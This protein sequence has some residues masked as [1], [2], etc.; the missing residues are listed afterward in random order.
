[1][2]RQLISSAIKGLEESGR[3]HPTAFLDDGSKPNPLNPDASAPLASNKYADRA[4]LTDHF[5]FKVDQ[6]PTNGIGVLDR[7]SR[8]DHENAAA[9]ADGAS[10]SEFLR[11]AEQ[12]DTNFAE[13]FRIDRRKQ[14]RDGASGQILGS[15]TDESRCETRHSSFD[16]ER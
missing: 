10:N 7:F 1:M 2:I 9:T 8:T 11:T 14:R 13:Q 12:S 5:F 16:V 3:I 6:F 4:F 15:S